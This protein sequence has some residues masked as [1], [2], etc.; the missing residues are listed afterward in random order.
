MAAGEYVSVSS[1]ADIERA[2]LA[3]ERTK[4][5]DSPDFEMQELTA[6]YKQR[7]Q[8]ICAIGATVTGGASPLVGAARVTSRETRLRPWTT[9]RGGRVGL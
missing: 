9:S 1:Q 5:A 4:V 6:I 3:T 2:E 8:A 7:A